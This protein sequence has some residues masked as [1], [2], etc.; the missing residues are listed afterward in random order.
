MRETHQ[1]QPQPPADRHQLRECFR[2]AYALQS[3]LQDALQ[4]ARREGVAADY[5]DG[6]DDDGGGG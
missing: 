3:V 6:I 5:D 4:N 1:R 2:T